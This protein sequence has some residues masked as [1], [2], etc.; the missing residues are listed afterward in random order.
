MKVSNVLN[1]EIPLNKFSHDMIEEFAVDNDNTPWL[2]Q[3][4]IELEEDNDDDLKRDK[5]ELKI[6]AQAV[7]K[8][9]RFLG[10]N[11]VFKSKID[12]HYH[13]PCGRC[14]SPIRQDVALELNGAF[15]NEAM[16]KM[17]EYSEVTT[18]YADGEEMELYFIRKGQISIKD[19]FH[20]QLFSEVAPFPRCDGECKGQIYF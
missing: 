2:Q 1:A 4:I 14:L 20:E 13:L 3:I 17:P 11:L 8:N 12:G 6:S 18:V 7:R 19:F 15:L 10:D 5:A 9:D 16:E